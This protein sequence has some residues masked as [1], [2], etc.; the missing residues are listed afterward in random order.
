MEKTPLTI[1]DAESVQNA[2]IQLI[3][4]YPDYPTGFK[5]SQENVVWNNLITERS[6][7]IFPLQGAFYLK[8]YVSGSFRAQFPFRIVYRS[9]P[10]GNP[11][12]IAS[13]NLLNELGR[14]LEECGIDFKD[15]SV[16]LERVERTSIAFPI[17]ASPTD[18]EYAINMKLIYYVKK[19]MG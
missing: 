10:K 8:K 11:E 14:Y 2:L 1:K 18:Q 13:Q 5:A 7:G 17:G 3:I 16:T 15:N 6:F 4:K 9:Y 12:T 19:G